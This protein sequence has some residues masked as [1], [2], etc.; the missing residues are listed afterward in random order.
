MTS[1][2][3]MLDTAYKYGCIKSPVVSREY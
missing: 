3:C 1:D 2:L